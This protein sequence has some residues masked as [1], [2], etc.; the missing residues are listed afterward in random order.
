MAFMLGDFTSGSFGG[1]KK[2]SDIVEQYDKFKDWQDF[3]KARDQASAQDAANQK[4]IPTDTGAQQAAKDASV[5]TGPYGRGGEHGPDRPPS[6]DEY[7][8]TAPVPR[9]LQIQPALPADNS[10]PDVGKAFGPGAQPASTRT[11]VSQSSAIPTV[12]EKNQSTPGPVDTGPEPG[13]TSGGGASPSSVWNTLKGAGSSVWNTMTGAGQ[14]QAPYQNQALPTQRSTPNTLL[15]T[16]NSPGGTAPVPSTP[17]APAAAGGPQA[18]LGMYG[19][20]PSLAQGQ[21]G[22]GPRILAALNPTAGS[23][24]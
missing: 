20:M 9:Y 15:P 11:P 13:D 8:K 22:M 19:Q 18:A 1:F 21:S 23:T 12:A 4:A 2:V 3:K 10:S 14:Q 16:G 5:P 7:I 24:T 6:Y 17:N